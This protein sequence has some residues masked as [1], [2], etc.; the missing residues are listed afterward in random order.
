[1]R[2]QEARTRAETTVKPQALSKAV[3]GAGRRPRAPGMRAVDAPVGSRIR[4]K[5][6][7]KGLSQSALGTAIGVTFQQMQKY[8]SG[9]NRVSASKLWALCEELDVPVSY[10]FDGLSG[11][12]SSEPEQAEARDL[13]NR[14]TLTLARA[15]DR[16]R[17][18]DQ[19][20]SLVDLAKSMA[21]TGA[22]G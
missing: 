1:M 8:E 11:G 2:Q 14:E 7:M 16:I 12:A 3:R 18:P 20:R 6:I 19:R 4:L 17:D 15:F 22:E 21:K 9:A 10:F 13:A 5:R